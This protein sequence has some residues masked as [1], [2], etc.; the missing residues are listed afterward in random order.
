[1][2]L[3]TTPVATSVAGAAAPSTTIYDS[4]EPSATSLVSECYECSQNTEIG[5]QVSFAPG[6]RTLTGVTVQ[7]ESW[8]CETGST[9][10]SPAECI[11]PD[12]YFS[13]PITLNLYNV[14]N[15]GVSRGSLI[16]S[17][18][19]VAQIKYRPTA[20]PTRCPT[21][22][23]WWDGTTCHN[24]IVS[25]VSFDLGHI[26]VPDKV[27][28][29][30]AVNTADYG[31]PPVPCGSQP[32]GCPANS[33]NIGLT[34]TDQPQP[35]V[36]SDP[37]LGALYLNSGNG[38]FY[39][40]GGTGG[41]GTFRADL[42]LDYATNPTNPQQS[43][44]ST[45]SGAAP[46]YVPAVSFTTEASCTAVC[47]VS[48]SGDDSNSGNADSPFATIQHAVTAVQSG[49]TVHV[50]AGTYNENVH[51]TQPVTLLGANAGVSG[52]SGARSA[53][54]V[55]STSNAGNDYT[56]QV[57]SSGVTVDGFTLQ[58]TAPSCNVCAA[59][60]VQ[61]DP[62][63]SGADVTNNVITGMTTLNSSGNPIGVDI[64]GNGG[65]TPNG[66]HVTGNL[67]ENIT[68]SGT[69]TKSALGIEVGDSS[70]STVGSG[71]VIQ[72]N[73][74]TG[75]HSVR[76]AYGI[77]FNR[78]TTGSQVVGNTIDTL[79]GTELGPRHRA[80]GQTPPRP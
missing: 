47:Y 45:G 6:N 22:S 34:T 32:T 71:L 73:H 27:I 67:I 61:V 69:P 12:E 25:P 38:G 21:S 78:P 10:G 76:G 40:D 1:M 75:I 16:T 24:G 42:P 70:V 29:G 48:P 53:E 18:S 31:T 44:W 2:G 11:S 54:S 23:Q 33:L 43:C 26:T 74:I 20:D 41:S 55:I 17:V 63:A 64:A 50:A 3:V 28:Y 68:S 72:G 58:Q 37:I 35:S 79:Y 15:D 57:S 59:F 8:A 13:Q 52:T 9:S 77:I 30:V 56:V 51:I 62:N 5:N 60:G 80:R 39:C 14:A 49:G 4:T 65:G 36:G 7:M 66:V 46:Y 19:E